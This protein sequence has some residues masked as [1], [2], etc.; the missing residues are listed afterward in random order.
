MSSKMNDNDNQPSQFKMLLA[1]YR[2][3]KALAPLMTPTWFTPLLDES[4]AATAAEP[5]R[6]GD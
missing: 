5:P 4:P 1:Y 3:L 6:L 2:V